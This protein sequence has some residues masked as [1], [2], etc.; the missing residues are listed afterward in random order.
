MMIAIGLLTAGLAILLIGAKYFVEGIAT[1]AEAL[2]VSPLIVGMTVV[3]FGTSTPELVVNALAAY[4]GETALAFGNIIGSCAINVGFVL[5]VTAL[6]RPLQVETSLITREVPM[7][8]VAVGAILILSHDRLL[9]GDAGDSL[10]RA[11]GMIL[12]LLFAI[13]LYYTAIYSIAKRALT[14]GKEDAFISEVREE[15]HSQ[16]RKKLAG[17]LGAAALGLVGVSLGAQWTVEGATALARLWGMSDNLIGLTIVSFGTTLPE[18]VTCVMAARSGNADIALGNVVGS[19]LFNL[20]AIGGAVATIR[21]VPVPAGGAV[22]LLFMALLTVVLLPI[23]IRSGRTIT[24]GE[25]GFLLFSY[26]IFL[27]WRLA[28][29]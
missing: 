15:V 27:G 11:D 25:G 3:A 18:L 21:P 19:N 16:P 24:R 2:G 26:L 22:D 1:L 4:R 23:A 7:L 29:G 28:A 17:Q 6:V 9:N 12:L 10:G 5:A 14:G 20:L 8:W 13:F